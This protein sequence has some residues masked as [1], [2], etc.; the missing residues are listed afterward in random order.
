MKKER[1]YE[2]K[3][4]RVPTWN[5][6]VGCR[7]N[8]TYCY[9]RDIAKRQK[10]RCLECYEFV[11]HLH[12]ERLLKKY[13]QG[14]TVFVCSMGDI[15][16]ATFDTF[17]GILAVIRNQ[18]KTTFYIQSKDPIYFRE[19]LERFGCSIGDNV[20]LG[21]TIETNR[22]TKEYSYAPLPQ[23]RY[24]AMKLLSHCEYVTIE[25]IMDFDMDVMVQWIE[26]IKPEFVYIGYNSRD[27]DTRHLPE[28]SLAKTEALIE[29]LKKITEVRLKLIR[30]AWWEN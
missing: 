11:P 29:K 9:A 15:S 17:T 3:G 23:Y 21:T 30:M 1:M 2:I 19:Y 24:D 5:P 18:P 25:P 27:R 8:C 28:P 12:P 22:N 13:K 14:E 7:H 16:F 20:I 26:E 6:Y 10:H 4:K